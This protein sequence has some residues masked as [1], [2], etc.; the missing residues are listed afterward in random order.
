MLSST[1][2]NFHIKYT[3]KEQPELYISVLSL[4]KLFCRLSHVK[5]YFNPVLLMVSLEKKGGNTAY[6]FGYNGACFLLNVKS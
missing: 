5:S 1:L 2:S 3:P 4:K 6:V